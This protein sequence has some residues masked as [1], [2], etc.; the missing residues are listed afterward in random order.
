MHPERAT[1]HN[2]T[3]V[4]LRGLHDTTHLVRGTNGEPVSGVVTERKYLCRLPNG[5]ET[6]ID[7]NEIHGKEL[8]K[9]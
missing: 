9:V 1:L 4:L 2:G 5:R 3:L 8:A 6:W 7:A